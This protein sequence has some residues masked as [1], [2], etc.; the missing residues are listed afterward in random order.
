MRCEELPGLLG[1]R[2][3][4]IGILDT[5]RGTPTKNGELMQFI[6]MEDETGVFEVTLFP[7][8]YARTRRLLTDCGPYVV[9]GRVEEQYGSIS[10]TAERVERWG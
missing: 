9:T 8:L 10:I 4:M 3:R 5:T 2:V 1:R 6:T 7:K